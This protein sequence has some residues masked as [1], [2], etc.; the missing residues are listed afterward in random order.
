MKILL[1][2][3]FVVFGFNACASH[4]DS[5]YYN[6]ANTASEKALDKLDRE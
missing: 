3:L 1:V 4:Q 5:G 6:R 2:S